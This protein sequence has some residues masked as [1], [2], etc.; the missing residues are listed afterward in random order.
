[1]EGIL[2]L[3]VYHY[4]IIPTDRDPGF[5]SGREK[6]QKG[7]PKGKAGGVGG[8]DLVGCLRRGGAGK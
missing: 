1:M 7:H 2:G 3:S 6:S 8:D 5:G 4:D